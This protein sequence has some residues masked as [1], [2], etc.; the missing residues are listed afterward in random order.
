MVMTLQE[1]QGRDTELP[2]PL[3][4]G[5]HPHLPK[6][7]HQ[8]ADQPKLAS[9]REINLEGVYKTEQDKYCHK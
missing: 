4:T 2:S 9:V 7:P 5:T 8:I 1:F 6:G 3:V